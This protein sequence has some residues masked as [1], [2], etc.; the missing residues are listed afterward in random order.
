MVKILKVQHNAGWT[1]IE[2]NFNTIRGRDLKVIRV[3][4]YVRVLVESTFYFAA[5]QSQPRPT[6]SWDGC[7]E[8]CS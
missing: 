5:K 1:H 7:S 3:E 2:G 4:K 8:L 6:L